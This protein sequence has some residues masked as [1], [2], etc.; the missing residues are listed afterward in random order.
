VSTVYE[1]L[2]NQLDEALRKYHETRQRAS[3][4]VEALVSICVDQLGFPHNSF[5]FRRTPQD[6]QESASFFPAPQMECSNNGEWSV[7]IDVRVKSAAREDNCVT[8]IPVTIRIKDTSIQLS[9]TDDPDKSVEI[10]HLP[11]AS[12][13][14]LETFCGW[15]REKV[16]GTFRWIATGEGRPERRMGFHTEA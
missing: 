15:I 16:E 8:F 4:I 7:T 9:L 3:K 13:T 14:D 5:M 2:Q 6:A 12:R 1:N 11:G 10:S